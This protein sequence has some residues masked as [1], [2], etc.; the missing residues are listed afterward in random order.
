MIYFYELKR[1]STTNNFSRVPLFSSKYYLSLNLR[2]YLLNR[3]NTN[4]QK[5]IIP[6]HHNH[7]PTPIP[8]NPS[9]PQTPFLPFLPLLP[10]PFLP[11]NIPYNKYQWVNAIP[12]VTSQQTHHK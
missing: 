4:Q 1:F 11:L 12:F 9:S 7:N 3:K 5:Q 8:S 6:N 2:T 10:S